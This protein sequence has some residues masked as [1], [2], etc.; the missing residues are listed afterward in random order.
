[1]GIVSGI[2][3]FIL[4]WWLTFFVVVPFGNKPPEVV[5]TGH[6]AGAP[7]KPRLWMKVGI[8]TAIAAVLFAIVWVIQDHG[9][10]NLRK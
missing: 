7:E 9:W 5:E 4:I 8:T 1:M 10:I 6:D 3:T 2:V